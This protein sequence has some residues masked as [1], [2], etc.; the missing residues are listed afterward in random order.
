MNSVPWQP[1][2]RVWVRVKSGQIETS[3]RTRD[4]YVQCSLA[5]RFI[6]IFGMTNDELCL[7]REAFEQTSNRGWPMGFD[8]FSFGKAPGPSGRHEK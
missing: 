1:E 6:G 7:L 3:Q 2:H 4:K 8:G 5:R